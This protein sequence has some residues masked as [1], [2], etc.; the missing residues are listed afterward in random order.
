MIHE[1]QNQQKLVRIQRF[2]GSTPDLKKSEILGWGLAIC[3]W[4]NPPGNYDACEEFENDWRAPYIYAKLKNIFSS[5]T[6]YAKKL[7]N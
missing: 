5:K 3:F 2:P 7:H 1:N 6:L 4:K